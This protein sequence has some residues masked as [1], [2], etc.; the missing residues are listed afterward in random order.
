LTSST[1]STN[2]AAK[3]GSICFPIRVSTI[4][5]PDRKCS[6]Q[7]HSLKQFLLIST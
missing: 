3:P 2:S 4:F 7:K 1:S 6:F 5:Q